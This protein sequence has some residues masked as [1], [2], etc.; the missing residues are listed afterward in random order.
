MAFTIVILG[1]IHACVKTQVFKHPFVLD[2]FKF[3]SGGNVNKTNVN[4]DLLLC[5]WIRCCLT[6]VGQNQIMVAII[7][8]DSFLYN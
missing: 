8:S 1:P 6:D 2:F 5:F 3:Y 7:F 4:F